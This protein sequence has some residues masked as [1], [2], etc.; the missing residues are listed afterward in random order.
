LTVTAVPVAQPHY[1]LFDTTLGLCGVAWSDAGLTRVQLP[2]RDAAATE[3]RLLKYATAQWDGP[4]PPAIGACIAELRAYFDGAR[5]DFQA[6]VLDVTG[7]ADFNARV[8]DALRRVGFGATTTYGALA[9]QVGSPGA[10]Q[11][12]GTAM[13][14]NPWPVVVPCHRVLA[15]ARGMGGF[16]AYGGVVTKRHLLRLEG[17]DLDGGQ[18]GLPGI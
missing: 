16:S 1:H 7:V 9:T 18:L 3:Q 15:A 2:E 5:V 12:V 4:L 13:A 8:Y 10:A 11:A 17:V 6:A 14:R